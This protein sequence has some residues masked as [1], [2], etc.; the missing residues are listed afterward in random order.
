VTN[1]RRDQGFAGNIASI[2]AILLIAALVV[3]T[4]LPK[5][6]IFLHVLHKTG[7]P[8]AFGLIALLV[9]F[10]LAKRDFMR[11]RPPWAAYLAAF[12]ITVLIGVATEIAQLFT[13]RDARVADVISD[14]VG[15]TACLAGY[16]AAFGSGRLAW[17]TGNR[18]GAAL[19]ALAAAGYSLAPLTWCVAAYA[20]RDAKF[21]VILENPSRLDMYF[22]A[23]DAGNLSVIP[24]SVA[25]HENVA[26]PV[27]VALDKGEYPGL[28]IIEPYPR[29]SGYQSLAVDITNPGASD[30]HIVIRVHDRQ[31][32]NHYDDR[33]N[34]DFTLAAN[35]R[36]TILIPMQ[37]I[38]HGAKQRL[39][40]LDAIAG[41][42]LFASGSVPG[43]VFFVNRIWLS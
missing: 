20:V 8:L 4:G 16:A 25:L 17:P 38:Q 32:K 2:V 22:V 43:G 24:L 35:S 12:V 9:F 3:F 33:F 19:V 31:H 23:T 28:S 18:L 11:S 5:T 21:P 14:A 41:L 27:K 26:A 10:L 30:L 1:I 34:R 13:H 6:T 37:D 40:K 7:H 15:A 42:I 36:S 39:L 29:W